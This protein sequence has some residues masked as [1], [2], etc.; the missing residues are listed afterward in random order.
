MKYILS[1]FVAVFSLAINAQVVEVDNERDYQIAKESGVIPVMKTTRPSEKIQFEPGKLDM[2][3]VKQGS[4]RMGGGGQDECDCIKPVD[5]TYSIAPMSLG[6]SPGEAPEYR[7]DD[8]HTPE[9]ELPFTFCLYGAQYNSCWIN[10]NGNVTFNEGNSGFTASG[11]PDDALVM[12]APFW[13]DVDTRNEESGLVY[14]KVTDHYMI[15]YWD[16]VG[17]F[18]SQADKVN[19]F[20][21]IIS[22]GTDP[23]IP[24]GGNVSICYG[25]MQWTTGSANSG[26]NG[27]GGT[28][29]TV[30]ANKG[31]GFNYFQ[32]G[33]FSVDSNIYDGPVGND[34]GINW[35]DNLI[36]AFD[37]CTTIDTGNLIPLSPLLTACNLVYL[38]AGNEI[39]VTFL[40]PEPEQVLNINWQLANV[41]APFVFTLN[42]PQAGVST[43]DIA[44]PLDI[45]PGN[46][47]IT[48]TASDNGVPAQQVTVFYTL[49]V[50]E[51]AGAIDILGN[52]TICNGESTQLSIIPG[53]TNIEWS[54]GSGGNSIT[55]D[56][57][58]T[59]SVEAVL[60]GCETSGSI[61]VTAPATAIPVIQGDNSICAGTQTTLTTA[62]E[63][64]SY[65]W[66][67]GST[68]SSTVTGVGS[69]SLTT[70]D[71]NGCVGTGNFVV[72]QIVNPDVIPSFLVC[73]SFEA[74]VT[75][76]D[77]PGSWSLAS[78]TGLDIIDINETDTDIIAEV[79]G[80]Y[81]IVFTHAECNT[82]DELT[83][84]FLP[85]PE[86][87]LP[88][89]VEV[90][91]GETASI[92]PISGN[93]QYIES[94]VWENDLSTDYIYNFSTPN[95]FSDSLIFFSY[96]NDCASLSDTVRV[97]QVL[98]NIFIPNVFTPN[99]DGSNNA[100]SFGGITQYSGN[101]LQVFNRWGD[102]IF[103][104]ANYQNNWIPSENEVQDGVY[105]FIL[106]INRPVGMEYITGEITI[107]R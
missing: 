31:D 66:S 18:S 62:Q 101:T 4:S 68:E 87:N 71:A 6:S 37:A 91:F 56:Q 104:S 24:N 5:E 47:D 11:F 19:S 44:A 13:A 94:F 107:M 76:N 63:F 17:Y 70:T 26:V 34:D 98:C 58:G 78:G 79:Y 85:T 49:V 89:V 38:C 52:N 59:Y 21:L 1:L 40:G 100:L 35:L 54:T 75:G 72:S 12:V 103:E 88:N 16:A 95:T 53:Y 80:E 25:D 69:I 93:F 2:S 28:P 106:G 9:I 8:S 92:Q 20:Q 29:A 83:V 67:N 10:N 82:T 61:E 23:I 15:V 77:V 105:F 30:G 55:V 33:R 51:T 3:K 36:F 81:T 74:S 14:Y 22:D 60:G 73:D 84:T 96:E 86:A 42:P 39:T 102:M 7:S 43:L 90:C 45:P 48:I 57:P 32:A 50:I 46:Y 27:F 65:Q 99:G 64:V 97:R 41:D